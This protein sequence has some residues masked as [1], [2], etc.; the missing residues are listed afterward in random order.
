[1]PVDAPA[2]KVR[3]T[4]NLLVYEPRLCFE[5]SIAPGLNASLGISYRFVTNLTG[6]YG[7]YN[8][9]FSG[10]TGSVSIRFGDYR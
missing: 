7:I 1:L 10:P 6:I 8:N 2:K 3:M 9:D 5:Y 4:L